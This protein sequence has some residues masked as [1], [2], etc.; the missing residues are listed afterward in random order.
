M[1]ANYN[2]LMESAINGNMHLKR[3]VEP[4]VRRGDAA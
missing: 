2:E 4:Y 1:S 3:L